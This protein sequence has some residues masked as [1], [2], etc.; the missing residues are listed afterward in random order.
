MNSTTT[1]N[2]TTKNRT[3]TSRHSAPKPA[4]QITVSG[5]PS[6]ST[7][8]NPH[9]DPDVGGVVVRERSPHAQLGPV[10]GHLVDEVG[11]PDQQRDPGRAPYPGRGQ[12]AGAARPPQP[13]SDPGHQ[14]GDQQLVVRR[15]P[16]HRT[17]DQPPPRLR[18][19]L[20]PDH[21][22]RDQRPDHE[23]CR[24]GQQYMTERS[25]ADVVGHAPGR[26]GLRLPVTPELAGDQG[27]EDEAG[28]RADGRRD[29]QQPRAAVVQREEPVRDERGERRLV[30]VP[31]RG[32]E[33]REV[34][35][36]TVVPVPVA[37]HAEHDGEQ[38][39]RRRDPPPGNRR[40]LPGHPPQAQAARSISATRNAS[41]SDCT[42]FRRGSHTDS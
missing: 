33:H 8:R 10:V 38:H 42:R 22:Q 39:G 5:G 25:R 29:P 12:P 30:D 1:T 4:A 9:L 36:V 15:Q 37:G 19:Q 3:R 28:D 14:H 20:G 18:P 2:T 32:L 11:Q 31:P 40:R 13:D 35:L 26:P 6:S 21:A 23:V 16:G 7:S 17:G 24:R 34:E 41:S 27:G